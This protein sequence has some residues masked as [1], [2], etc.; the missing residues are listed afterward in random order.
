MN[1]QLSDIVILLL[2]ASIVYS[3]WRNVS[4][5]EQALMRVKQHC[6]SLNLQLLEGSVAG[7]EWRPT[8]HHGQVKIKRAYKFEFSSSGVARYSGEIRYLGDQQV[9]IWLSPHDF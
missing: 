2:L 6:D 5:R 4:I 8:W 3:W 7:T 9:N 1:L